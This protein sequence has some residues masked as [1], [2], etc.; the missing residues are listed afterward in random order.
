MMKFPPRLLS[1]ST[2]MAVFAALLLSAC[3]SSGQPLRPRSDY[4]YTMPPDLWRP[5]PTPATPP[6]PAPAAG[7]ETEPG[8]PAAEAETEDSG[9]S[10]SWLGGLFSRNKTAADDADATEAANDGLEAG[11][12][13][14]TGQPEGVGESEPEINP[15]QMSGNHYTLKVGDAVYISLSGSGDLSEQIETVVDQ[16]GNVKLRF[17][18][19]V[20]AHGRTPTELEDEIEAEYTERQKIYKEV[21]ARVVVPNTFYFIGGEVRQPGRFPLLGR[22][23]L[24]QAIV[25]A[26]NFTEWANSK[27]VYLVRD[28]ERIELDFREIKEEPNLDVELQPGDVITVDRSTF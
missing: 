28:N 3:A 22:V 19:A 5:T 16:Q 15:I 13:P 27:R 18:G 20:R 1:F 26:G 6:E 14:E 2:L 12:S 10:R 21:V 9:R 17:I 7:T 11:S 4:D 23:T 24:S 8:E 25:A